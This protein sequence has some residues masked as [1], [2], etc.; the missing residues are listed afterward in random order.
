[1]TDNKKKPESTSQSQRPATSPGRVITQDGMFRR[2]SAQDRA[3]VLKEDRARVLK[4]SNTAAPP[5]N[6]KGGGSNKGGS[7]R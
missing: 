3:G 6:P 4:V 1:M 5:P 7:G 2:D